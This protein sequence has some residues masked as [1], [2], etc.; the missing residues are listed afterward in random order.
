MK[1]HRVLLIDDDPVTVRL[2]EKWLKDDGYE[3]AGALSG[4]AA[5]RRIQEAPCQ[6][7]VLDLMVPDINGV[8]LAKRFTK[9]KEAADLP[10]IFVTM[11]IGVENDKGDERIEIDGRTYPA[12]AKPIHRAKFLSTLRREI[13]R[14]ERTQLK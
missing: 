3:V 5:L 14:R 12:F 1:N 2:V 7:I 8:E 13:N 10:L 6:A 11:T 9:M 4:E